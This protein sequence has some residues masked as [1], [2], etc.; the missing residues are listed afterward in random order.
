MTQHATL[1]PSGAHRW[2]ACPGS[3]L[4]ERDIPDKDS[5]FSKEGTR[6]HEIA[7][8][9][10]ESGRPA[11]SI[12]DDTDM[13]NYV[14]EYVDL[15]RG[16]AEGG[17][18]MVEQRLPI[19][20]LTG[21]E[22]AKGTAD[23]VIIQGPELIV[24]DLKYGR[25]VKVD[26]EENDQLRMYALAAV[27]EFNLLGEFERVRM[28]IHQPRLGH[29]SEWSVP[30]SELQAWGSHVKAGASTCLDILS[31]GIAG[32]EDFNPGEKQC[33]FCKAKA[34]C[35]SLAAKVQEEIGA[36]FDTLNTF[37][38]EEQRAMSLHALK[39]RAAETPE[40]LAK[41]MGV[42]DLIESWCK[43]V[44]A[45]TESQLLAGVPIAGWK[46]VQGRKGA[47]AWGDAAEAEAQLK[48]MRLKVEQMYELS[49]ISPTTAEKLHKAGTIGPRQ[50]PKVQALI[51]QSEGKPSVAP[52]SDKRPALVVQATADEFTDEAE[53]EDLV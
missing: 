32:P 38:G 16:M 12:T 43:A 2:L 37:S 46:L 30:L 44:R 48:A 40:T 47:R 35:P 19:D 26:A 8:D 25:G 33:R 41:A 23:A 29:V 34:T 3:V 51:T 11:G 24:V 10:L 52:E 13:A 5:E 50:W 18:L 4:L 28:V 45:E 17:E 27:G 9:A 53:T 7:A 39:R 49:L 6:A 15:V 31:T 20:F 14:Q 21:E 22:D 42:V 1:S 36:E